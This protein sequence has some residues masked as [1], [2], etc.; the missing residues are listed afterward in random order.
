[1]TRLTKVILLAFVATNAV[2]D[3]SNDR[4]IRYECATLFSDTSLILP[5][6]EHEGPEVKVLLHG[7]PYA[8]VFSRKG[9]TQ[10]WAFDDDRGL[11]VQLDPDLTAGYFDF[12]GA[13]ENEQ[14]EPESLFFCSLI[15]S[16][17][18]TAPNQDL[19]SHEDDGE[20]E[21]FELENLESKPKVIGEDYVL[22]VGIAPVYPARA[23]A[24]G[25]EGYVDLS[26]TVTSSGT[27]TDLVVIQSSDSEFD[28]AAI[29]AVL[30]Y[31]Y[32]PR[33]VDGVPVDTPN[34]ETR[35]SF[36]FEN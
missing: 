34:V 25:L 18:T 21:N 15:R 29:R 13:E 35:I 23:L 7:M 11:Q 16:E 14:R 1:M 19:T 2:A 9:L 5:V 10:V 12:T 30:K 27:V 4:I 33:V 3:V 24:R 31:K 6:P 36:E 20:P 17:D 22:V 26:F 32:K 8:A 28:R